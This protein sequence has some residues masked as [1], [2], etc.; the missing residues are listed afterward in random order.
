MTV[1]LAH[2]VS[3]DGQRRAGR[4]EAADGCVLVVESAPE[5]TDRSKGT[6]QEVLGKREIEALEQEQILME[7]QFEP[8]LKRGESFPTAKPTDPT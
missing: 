3:V 8:I 5:A 6:G 1:D 4:S 2:R 7:D